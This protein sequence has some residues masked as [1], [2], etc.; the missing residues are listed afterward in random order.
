M[1][2]FFVH[3]GAVGLFLLGIIDGPLFTPFGI[4]VLLIVLT[5]RH[6]HLLP[7]YVV[8]AT[9]GSVIGY[10]IVDVLSRKGGEEGLKKK[11]KPQQYERLRRKMEKN[12]GRAIGIAALIPPPFPFT[13]VLAAAAAF[14]YPRKKLLLVLACTKAARFFII[15]LLARHYGRQLIGVF[16]SRGFRWFIIGLIILSVAGSAVTV[17]KWLKHRGGP[18]DR[19]MTPAEAK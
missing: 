12:A 3:L 17:Y 18:A 4:D 13:P 2:S 1:G 19:K 10:A 8:A 9:L 7:L 14:Q 6:P 11:M 5:A 16:Q 15:G